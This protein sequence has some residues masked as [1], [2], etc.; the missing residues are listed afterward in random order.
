M[1]G[2]AAQ[3][4]QLDDTVRRVVAASLDAQVA[5]IEWL[6]G[7][8]GL[9][10][11]A[12]VHLDA[13]RPRTLVALRVCGSRRQPVAADDHSWILARLEGLRRW[14]SSMHTSRR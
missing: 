8:L 2:A 7:Q 3:P 11:F 10:R 12:R 5:R 1:D 9:R 4:S 13:A 14:L 6:E